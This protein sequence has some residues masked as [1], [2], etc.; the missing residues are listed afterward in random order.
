V[1]F[2]VEKRYFC[3]RC[4]AKSGCSVKECNS[5]FVTSN[6][7][8]RFIYINLIRSRPYL[9][10][11]HPGGGE[12]CVFCRILAWTKAHGLCF[13][14]FKDD[15]WRGIFDGREGCPTLA[16]EVEPGW[17]AQRSRRQTPREQCLFGFASED[18]VDAGPGWLAGCRI[19]RFRRVLPFEVRRKQIGDLDALA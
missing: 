3:T 16:E 7:V 1:S 5:L 6:G 17:G 19:L 12:G 14:G 8:I 10:S 11:R 9:L 2:T 13:R 4:G 15:S 18:R